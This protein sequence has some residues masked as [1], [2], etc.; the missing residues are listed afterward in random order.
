VELRKSLAEHGRDAAA[1]TVQYNLLVRR[2]DPAPA[3]VPSVFHLQGVSPG[4]VRG[5]GVG[6]GVGVDTSGP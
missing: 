1:H 4:W 3:E 5:A 6:V 2:P